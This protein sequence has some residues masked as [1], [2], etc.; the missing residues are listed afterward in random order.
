MTE[1]AP[2]PVP[3]PESSGVSRELVVLLTSIGGGVLGLSLVLA[4]IMPAGGPEFALVVFGF[5]GALV[6]F[7]GAL[8]G[9][10]S[11]HFSQGARAGFGVGAFLAFLLLLVVLIG[12]PAVATQTAPVCGVAAAGPGLLALRSFTMLRDAGL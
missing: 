2:E 11:S 6:A 1:P 8:L 3:A 7:V 4:S 10:L 5:L 12:G 9:A